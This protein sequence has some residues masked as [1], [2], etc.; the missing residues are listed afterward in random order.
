MAKHRNFLSEKSDVLL[1]PV[2]NLPKTSVPGVR[3]FRPVCRLLPSEAL[4]GAFQNGSQ[5]L[6]NV[7]F[8]ALKILHTHCAWL[9]PKPQS[10]GDHRHLDTK[11][12]PSCQNQDGERKGE[13]RLSF[14]TDDALCAVQRPRAYG[15]PRG[16]L[17]HP[18]AHA[19]TVPKEE[20]E[21][22]EGQAAVDDPSVENLYGLCQQALNHALHILCEVEG[23][24]TERHQIDVAVVACKMLVFE[25]FFVSFPVSLPKE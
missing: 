23:R 10:V 19:G 25:F 20:E 12:S 5:Q 18:A 16:H 15:G 1:F 4:P 22:D 9:I 13:G 8:E 14:Q 3:Y 6:M 21:S 7:N 24:G 17:L 2:E 11:N